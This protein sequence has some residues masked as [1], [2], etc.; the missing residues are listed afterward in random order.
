MILPILIVAPSGKRGRGVFAGEKIAAK[1]VIEISPVLVLSTKDRK[2]VEKTKLF[3]YIFE[4]G[5]D[6]KQACIALGY[7]SLYNHA[8]DANCEY[9]M[10]F[11]HHLMTITTV[12]SIK[13]GEELFINYNASSDDASPVWFDAI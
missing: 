13:K 12:R 8:Y 7:L 5:P 10:D 1:T 2:E 3:D 4:W 11:E 6:G 9:E